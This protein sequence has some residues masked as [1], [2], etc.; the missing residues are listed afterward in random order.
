ML[1]AIVGTG[2][3]GST[4]LVRLLDGSPD[5]WVHPVEV[6]Y[7]SVLSDLLR[8]GRVDANTLANA[9]TRK[10]LHLDGDLD[11][12]LLMHFYASHF[13]ELDSAY[14]A[15]LEAPV[16]TKPDPTA[17]L[18]AKA[19]YRPGEFLPALL[20][21]ARDAYDDRTPPPRHLVFKTIETPYVEEYAA[22]FPEIR[23]VHILRNPLDNYSSLKRTNM[24]RKGWP[25]WRHGGD[26]LRMF[27]EKRWLPH[28]RLV[29]DPRLAASDRHVVVR[30]ED[31]VAQPE[32]TIAEVCRRLGVTPP[33][34]P[35]TL[36]ALG[37]KRMR[38]LPVNPSKEGVRTPERVVANMAE[39]FGYEEVLTERER[40][41]I[42]A[43]THGLA[44]SLGYDLGRPP[45]GAARLALAAR[46]LPPDRWE[47]VNA[48]SKARQAAAI[49]VRRWYIYRTLLH[50]SRR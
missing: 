31:L 50:P 6:N 11:A 4:L 28:A 1:I 48:R 18:R 43:R 45:G 9:T 46:W 36:T 49:L 23:F 20:E 37:G 24:V 7:L 21:A 8:S 47:L 38:E 42:V 29:T 12:H 32:E 17:P 25:F 14:V 15:N 26:E 19:R 40:Q 41:L 30:H 35:V 3:N 34:F 13:E 44:R 39:R 27:L 5:L 10:P 16:A 22:T 2:R 33:P